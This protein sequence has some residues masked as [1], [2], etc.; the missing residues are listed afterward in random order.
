MLSGLA[1]GVLAG[2]FG[3]G[4]GIVLVPVLLLLFHGQGFDPAIS[5]QLAVGSSLAA[6]VI[7]NASATW[8]HQRRGAVCWS[9]A[10]RYALG[11]LLGSWAGAQLAARMDGDLLRV[12]FGGFE[13]IVAWRMWGGAQVGSRVVAPSTGSSIRMDALGV[14]I[15]ALIGVLSALF[16]IGGGTLSVP[17][18][19]QLNR[20][21][22]RQAVAT[23]SAIGVVIAAS[24]AGGFVWA[25]AGHAALPTGAVGFLL[26]D[27]IAAIAVGTLIT[28]PLGVRLAHTVDPR[29]LAR[30]FA[31]FL[32]LVGVRL[33][34]PG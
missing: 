8:H 23:S 18:L 31:L 5:M 13:L 34:W 22:M 10:L 4:G 6:I 17:A 24:G 19:H 25:G 3:V 1:A 21:P 15:G 27:V 11:A 12:L 29:L 7:T 2:M 9:L 20:V 33:I 30:G 26:P 14:L 32:F 28:T 16:G